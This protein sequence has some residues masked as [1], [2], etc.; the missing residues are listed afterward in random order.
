MAEMCR[1]DL[2]LRGG[3]WRNQARMAPPMTVPQRNR[4]LNRRRAETVDL[5]IGNMPFTATVGFDDDDR[6]QEVFLD[7]PKTGSTMSAILGDAA[8]T[9]SIALQFGIPARALAKSVARRP[10]SSP[11][12]YGRIGG[13]SHEVDCGLGSEKR[14]DLDRPVASSTSSAAM[15]ASAR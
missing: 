6:P 3:P 8:V 9:I 11:A 14:R 1:H 10:R 15:R 12:R 2:T 7:G 13:L 4:L 5:T